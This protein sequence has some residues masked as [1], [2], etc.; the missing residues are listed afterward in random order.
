MDYDFYFAYGSNMLTERLRNRVGAVKVY[1]QARLDGWRIALSKRARDGSGKANIEP[2]S[3]HSVWGALYKLTALQ[4]MKLDRKEKG[5]TRRTFEVLPQAGP[6][7]S[8][9]TYIAETSTAGLRPTDKYRGLILNGAR[10][11]GL[12]SDYL[13]QLER[14]L[15]GTQARGVGLH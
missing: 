5:Y 15:A 4:L 11:H 1:G 13:A 8:A 9:D 14:V 12:P 2:S 10:E 3:A 7:V 6:K